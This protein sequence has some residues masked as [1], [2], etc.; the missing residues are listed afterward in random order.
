VK[1]ETDGRSVERFSRGE[2]AGSFGRVA[3]EYERGR[4]G[5]PR[6]AIDWLLGERP[7]DVLDVGAGTGKLTAALADAGHRVVA[8]EPLPEMRAILTARLPDVRTLAGSAEALPLPDACVDAVAVGSAFHWFDRARAMPE[9]KRVLRAPG[10]LGL[11]GN[12][13]DTSSR[14]VARVREILGP[15]ALQRPGHW[16][17]VEELERDFAEVE[18]REFPHVQALGR[19]SLRDLAVSRSSLAVLSEPERERVLAA[20]DRLW[21]EE[22]ELAGTAS[23]PMPWLARVRRCRGLR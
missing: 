6:A 3:E 22:P 17:S 16:P 4:P 2:R 10:V 1:P 12:G 5:Y 11:L 19:E 14:W 21:L 23:A 7:L 18:D 20:L 15:P 8:V 9:I 13:F